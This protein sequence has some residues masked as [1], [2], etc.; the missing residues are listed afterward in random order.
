MLLQVAQGNAFLLMP[1]SMAKASVQ[2]VT[3]KRLSPKFEQSL[4]IDIYLIWKGG[5][6]SEEKRHVID[7]FS[8]RLSRK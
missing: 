3:Y 4:L 8:E 5:D 2:G 7:Y 6:L 1:E